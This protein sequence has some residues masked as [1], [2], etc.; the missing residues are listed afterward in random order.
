[1]AD[2]SIVLNELRDLATLWRGD[3]NE[4]RLIARQFLDTRRPTIRTLAAGTAIT[5]RKL[6][7]LEGLLLTQKRLPEY[8]EETRQSDEDLYL[9]ACE[10]FTPSHNSEAASHR[11][12]KH[13]ALIDLFKHRAFSA[14]R[15]GTIDEAIPLMDEAVTHATKLLPLVPQAQ[16]TPLFQHR[17]YLMFHAALLRVRQYEARNDVGRA[18]AY[19]AQAREAA[20]SVA[21]AQL[22]PNYVYERADL[23][24][25]HHLLNGS[26]HWREGNFAEAAAVFDLWL[27]GTPSHAHRW[28]SRNI[29]VRRDAARAFACLIHGCKGCDDCRV[30]AQRLQEAARDD[31]I[32]AAGRH[33]ALKA[34]AVHTLGA[35][36]RELQAALD[37]LLPYLPIESQRYETAGFAG[38][39]EE[40]SDLPGYFSSVSAEARRLQNGGC[41][42]DA[43]S[44]FVLTRLR[45]LLNVYLEYESARAA[46]IG[47]PSAE[48]DETLPLNKLVDTLLEIR[49]GRKGP[50]DR[51]RRDWEFVSRLLERTPADPEALRQTYANVIGRVAGLFPCVVRIM[52]VRQTGQT[53]SARGETLSGTTLNIVTEFPIVA[54]LAYMPPRYRRHPADLKLLANDRAWFVQS[55]H[56]TGLFSMETIPLWEGK[57][58]DL[59]QHVIESTTIDYKEAIPKNIAKHV[60]AFANTKG[61]LIIVGIYDAKRLGAADAVVRGLSLEEAADTQGKVIEAAIIETDPPVA[62]PTFFRAYPLGRLVMMCRIAGPPTLQPHRTPHRHAGRIYVRAGAQS[63]PITEAVWHALPK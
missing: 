3:R 18:G 54:G 26:H 59:E 51:A 11:E 39:H 38:L 21:D 9:E 44:Q 1:M 49:L 24:L 48:L 7:C 17:A 6:L 50:R 13:K 32:G 14:V 62:P 5:L 33:V 55:K 36:G 42:A 29:R 47:L 40:S 56:L 35:S 2:E 52:E 34:F 27:L 25:Y 10:R 60:A 8:D 53:H 45:E 63:L 41:P 16:Y 58:S 20:D 46:R 19:L 4:Y 43:L 28:R 61:G 23:A 30:A 12:R 22:F 31:Q 15:R 57:W 37:D